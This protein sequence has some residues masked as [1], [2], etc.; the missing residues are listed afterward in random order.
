MNLQQHH[1]DVTSNALTIPLELS[2]LSEP[3]F[4]LPCE[5]RQ[6]FE[7]IRSTM[8]EEVRPRSNIEWL[9]TL[10]LVEL[11]WEI[12]RYRRMKQRALH[13]HR[14]AAIKAILLRLDGAGIPAAD[15]VHLAVQ[16][17]R[18]AEEW[19]QDPDAALEIEARLRRHGFNETS[20]DAELFCQAGGAFGTFDALLQRA[21]DRRIRL[22]R[23]INARR[24]F[25]KRLA[26]AS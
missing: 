4:L 18:S 23:E 12:L 19:R 26:N 10:D 1:R 14:P 11:S 3:S 21:Q 24:A 13:E 22:L 20:I 15:F 2:A 9:W 25:S 8:I 17:G 6:E 5:N 7:I 16:S